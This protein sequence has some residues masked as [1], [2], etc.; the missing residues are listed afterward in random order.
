MY[1]PGPQAY[2]LNHEGMVVI[3]VSGNQFIINGV[4]KKYVIR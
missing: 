2:Q 3:A 4:V 1:L